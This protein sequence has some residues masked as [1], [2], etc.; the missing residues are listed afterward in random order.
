MPKDNKQKLQLMRARIAAAAARIMAEDGVDDFSLA[1]RKAARQLGA[2]STH[3][4][5]DNGEIEEALRSY[6]SL[7]QGDE[8][9]QR[10]AAL[11]ERALAA[12]RKFAAFKPY[13][14]GAVLKGTAGRYS[15]IDLQLFTDDPKAVE[16]FLLNNKLSY[17]AADER[18]RVGGQARAVTVLRL[19]WDGVTLNL[20]VYPAN[21]ERVALRS[22]SGERLIERAGIDAVREL[23]AGQ[24]LGVRDD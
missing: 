16:L 1:K 9:R 24:E 22:A 14:W 21:D 23:I 5:P 12:M 15:D 20:S 8:Q 6:Q 17:E 13:L 18:R 19:D 2:E 10:V 3:A 11:R 7:Y 4:L